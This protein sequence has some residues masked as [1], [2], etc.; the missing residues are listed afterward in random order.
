MNRRMRFQASAGIFFLIL[1]LTMS[2]NGVEWLYVNYAALSKD[3]ITDVQN[4]IAT[5]SL[6]FAEEEKNSYWEPFLLTRNVIHIIK[7]RIEIDNTKLD[8]DNSVDNLKPLKNMLIAYQVITYCD[9]LLKI[10]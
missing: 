8:V 6:L 3:N 10:V 9:I 5:R 4:E 7:K 1:L 2:K